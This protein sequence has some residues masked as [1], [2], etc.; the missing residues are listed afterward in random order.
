MLCDEEL[1]ILE[2]RGDTSFF[3]NH[4]SGPSSLNL[5]KLVRS[6]LTVELGRMLRQARQ[7]AAVMRREQLHI[8]LHGSPHAV[9][10]EMVRVQPEGLS[11]RR[12]NAP[13]SGRRTS[14]LLQP[15]T[16][17]NRVNRHA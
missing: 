9:N 16:N 6:E 1:N 5:M 10:L 12:I 13:S 15:A 11:S 17:R 3:L 2:F 14:W 4:T 8:D 7:G